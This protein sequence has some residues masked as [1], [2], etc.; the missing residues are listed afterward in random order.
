L[1]D[2]PLDEIWAEWEDL[3]AQGRVQIEALKASKAPHQVQQAINALFRATHT[4]KGMA[5]MMGF[6]AFARSAHRL[7]DLFDLIRKGKLRSTDSLTETL[8]GG[9]AALEAGFN[10]LRKGRPEPDDYLYKLRKALGELEALGKLGS[11]GTVDLSH[12]LDL[13]EAHRKG[14]A[15]EERA[16]ITV[17]LQDGI[18]IH[19]LELGLGFDIFDQVL[20]DV[21]N[22]LGQQGEIISTLPVEL[23]DAPDQ[24]GFLILLAARHLDLAPLTLPEGAFRGFRLLG[25]PDRVPKALQAQEP[26][27]VE[28]A[29]AEVAAPPPESATPAAE[30]EILRLP[31]TTVLALEGE[32]EEVI[33][34]RDELSRWAKRSGSEEAS[35]WLGAMESRLLGLQ[36]TLLQM[37]MVKVE[38]FFQRLDPLLKALSRELGKPVKLVFNGGDLELERALVGKL[39]EPFVHLIRN[40]FD[41]GLEPPEERAAQGKGETGNIRISASQ[42]GRVLRF[43]IRDDGRGFD[44]ERIEAKARRLGLFRPED[45]PTSDQLHRMVFEPGFTTKDEAG[46]ISGRGVGMDAVREE[47]ERLGGEVHLTSEWKRGSLIRLSFPMSKAIVACLKV[48]AG[49]ILYGIPLSGVVRVQTMPRPYRGGERIQVLGRELTFESLQSCM[50]RPDPPEGQRT[51]VVVAVQASTALTGV[52]LAVGVDSI[53]DRGEVLLRGLPEHAQPNGVL[54]VS[55]TEEGALWGLD[56]ENLVGLGMESLMKRVAHA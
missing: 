40:A 1:N 33:Q 16:R 41:H 10:D 46:A 9:M 34:L 14:L 19:G 39:I 30:V 55:F 45:K 8:E 43:D 12:L 20:R 2:Q 17:T 27:P 7:E 42:K 52:E 38:G 36:R 44:L 53:L 31:A 56:P 47:I 32:L 35:P 23:A 54:G 22:L 25:D 11:E 6:K 24:L 29:P 5:G 51:I 26:L 48:R 13:P 21:T 15:D 49:G 50:G 37:R 4:L 18:P 28:A 3:F